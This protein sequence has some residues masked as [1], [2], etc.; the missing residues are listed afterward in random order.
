MKRA[1]L[2]RLIEDRAKKRAVVLVTDLASGDQ[3]L[4][5]PSDVFGDLALA[6]DA[7]KQV[8]QVLEND[9]SATT[10]AGKRAV[11]ARC[12][13]TDPCQSA[14]RGSC[15]AARP[16]QCAEPCRPRLHRSGDVGSERIDRQRVFGAG[17][18]PLA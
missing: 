14:S 15:G 8:R 12:R 1:L 11:R 2:D 7:L 4:V 3:A 10:E 13:A 5:Y 17:P 16:G 9:E 6:P 18:R